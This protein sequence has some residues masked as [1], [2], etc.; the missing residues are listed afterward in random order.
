MKVRYFAD[1]DTLSGFARMPPHVV[2]RVVLEV[3]R[4]LSS[5][6]WSDCYGHLRRLDAFDV[7]VR[8]VVATR[9]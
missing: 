9:S 7:G 2:D 8:L 5:G 4:D 1:T 6:V 3:S